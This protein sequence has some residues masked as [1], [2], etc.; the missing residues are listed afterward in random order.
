MKK[1]TREQLA[2]MSPEA[3]ERYEIRL[4]KVQR[5]RKILTG[6][7]ALLVVAA[8]GAVLSM[9]VL[10]NISSIKVAKKGSYYS[11]KEILSA[12]GFDVGDNMV[13]TNF[14]DAQ[15]RIE[16]MLPYVL[17][18]DIQKSL[19]G[20]VTITITDNKASVIF[21]VKN[22]YALADANG[23][24]LELLP[25]QPEE[26]KYMVLISSQ[27]LTAKIGEYIGFADEAEEKLYNE[28]CREL[29]KTGLYEHIT[30]LDISQP[31][32]IKII[33]ENRLR[34]KVGDISHINSKLTAAAKSIEIENETNPNTIAEINASILKKV[35][36]NPLDSLEEKEPVEEP[37]EEETTEDSD[38]EAEDE[39]SSEEAEDSEDDSEEENEEEEESTEQAEEES[40]TEENNTEE[41]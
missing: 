14:S 19:S 38:E 36:V 11:E 7:I 1:L 28:I 8:I 37:E 21:A 13:R 18:A 35:Y 29:I 9:T 32:N 3:R 34:I 33:Y 30:A 27:E 5:N 25:E 6:F 41:E 31:A 16:T 39:E 2:R 40:E 22:G 17:K 12:S 24:V 20:A 10:F 4:K 26:S 23:K 15:N